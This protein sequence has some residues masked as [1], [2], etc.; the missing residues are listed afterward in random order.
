MWH[1]SKMPQSEV[2]QEVPGKEGEG[3][4]SASSIMAVFFIL[5]AGFSLIFDSWKWFAFFALAVFYFSIRA[6]K[7]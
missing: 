5:A 7:L 2:C 4:I 1:V 6:G 3:V